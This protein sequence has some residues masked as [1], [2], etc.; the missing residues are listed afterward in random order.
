MEPQAGTVD[1]ERLE[2]M[3]VGKSRA[4]LVIATILLTIAAAAVLGEGL[5]RLARVP[6]FRVRRAAYIGWAQPDDVLGWR[7]HPGVFAA[8][9]RPH[10]PMTFLP[11]GSRATGRPTPAEGPT[12]LIVGCSYAEGYGVGDDQTFASLLQ[13]R[14]PRL[15]IQDFGT[16]GYSTYQSLMLLREVV[17]QHRIR[18][19]AVIYGFLPM[20]AERNVLTYSMLDAFRGFG[21]QR[22]AP[23][24]VEWAGGGLDTFPPFSV[25]NWPLEEQSALVTLLHQAELRVRLANRERDE[26]KV[27]ARLLQDMKELVARQNARLL[28][29][30]LWD[31]GPPGP[32]AYRRMSA[33]MG[34]AGI[35]EMDVTYRGPETRPELLQVGGNGHPSALIHAWWAD[36]LS[37]WIA[38]Q[39]F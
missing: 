12:V 9:E 34:E 2:T 36:K 11:D 7:N 22:F 18:P 23:P 39:K 4:A 29:A 28:V 25:R 14:F 6:V 37:A 35:E 16:P 1:K 20:H 8:D 21:G 32:E 31:G 10:E 13:E 33:S 24:H 17:E 5:A 15:R 27:T 3:P 26:E 19:A 38:Q 30:T